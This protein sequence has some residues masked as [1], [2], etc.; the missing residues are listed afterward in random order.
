MLGIR[1]NIVIATFIIRCQIS[2][3][4]NSRDS[5]ELSLACLRS[6]SNAITII[7]RTIHKIDS[8]V[9]KSIV[10]INSSVLILIVNPKTTIITL[11][12]STKSIVSNYLYKVFYRHTI[13]ASTHS[14]I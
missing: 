8:V 11:T 4:R 14:V 1:N 13:I 3:I 9:F 2:T 6:K 12:I 5:S 10:E 7:I